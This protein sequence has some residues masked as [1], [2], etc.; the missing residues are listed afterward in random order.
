MH[1]LASNLGVKTV[2]KV[3]VLDD[4]QVGHHVATGRTLF[5]MPHCDCSLYNNLVKANWGP[6]QM[7]KIAILGMCIQA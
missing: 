6:Q 4:N 5:F 7:H 1:V 3:Q 2:V